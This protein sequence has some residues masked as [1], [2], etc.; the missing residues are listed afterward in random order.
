MDGESIETKRNY[1][2]YMPQQDLSVSMADREGES[3]ASDGDPGR[4]FEGT[5]MREKADD[6]AANRLDLQD[7]GDKTP[8]ELSGGM[9]QRAALC[10]NGAHGF[11]TFCF[12]MSRF[13]P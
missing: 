12:S 5:E 1:C 2:G 4:I 7:W 9:R 8:K 3:D 13:Q 10:E 11:Q 6:G